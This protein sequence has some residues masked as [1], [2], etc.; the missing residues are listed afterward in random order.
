MGKRID[1]IDIAKGLTIM[2]VAF[3]HSH[4]RFYFPVFHHIIAFFIMPVFFFLSGVFF[5]TNSHFKNFALQKADL[6]LKPYFVTLLALYA[7]TLIVGGNHNETWPL[8][9]MLYGTGETIRWLPLWFLTHLWAVFIFS[10][11]LFKASNINEKPAVFKVLTV[12]VLL[13]VGT[14]FIDSF[15]KQELSVFGMTYLLPGLPFSL[16][17]IC[18]ST[19]FFISGTFLRT[20]V[21]NFRPNTYL[22]FVSVTL[23]LGISF[24]SEAKLSLNVRLYDGPIYST[25]AAYTGLYIILCCSFLLSKNTLS[26]KVF[27]YV[28]QASLFVYIFHE[29]IGEQSY[30][31][32]N[33]QTAQNHEFLSSVLALIVCIFAPLVIRYL[34]SRS[35]VLKLFYFPLKSNKLI[36]K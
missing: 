4:L 32:L 20:Q 22:L 34:I 15:W 23:L 26:K 6:L 17:L 35:E 5:S 2:F 30:K 14:T 25:V 24:F 16:D 28:G 12:L 3:H 13:L 36:S 18:V 21:M 7:A 31:V 11:I 27:V 19:A 1:I 8:E 33:K 9:G 29:Y 10:Y